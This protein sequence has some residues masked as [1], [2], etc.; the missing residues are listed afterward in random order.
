[1]LIK[2]REEE[3]RQSFG[4]FFDKDP[5]SP[6]ITAQIRQVEAIIEFE[7][8]TAATVS[9]T[10]IF[11]RRYIRRTAV[12]TLMIVCTSLSGIWFVA[13]YA[14]IFL[15]GLG[16]HNPY[17]INVAFSCC[18]LAGSFLSP[19]MA[20]YV[21]RRRTIIV[22]FAVMASSMLIFSAVSTGLGASSN[23]AR[24]VLVA[25]LCIWFF[26]FG[27]G[28]GSVVW[29]ASAEQHSVQYR[30]YSQAFALWVAF[31]FSFGGNFW[32]PYMLNKD[33]GNMGTNVGYF[34]FGLN[35]AAAIFS[36]FAVPET[37]R[38]TL[39]QI[40][41]F[42]ETGGK[43]WKTSLSQNKKVEMSNNQQALGPQK[44]ERLE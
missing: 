40:D 6:E 30:T 16:F 44:E 31:L 5:H 24:S 8:N 33:Y 41:E 3:A 27:S 11:K 28:P 26:T 9:W 15:A 2:A 17:V 38:L 25:F 20:E 14:T 7:R 22:G 19:F 37:A 21:G 36:F 13:P 39:E 34:Y 43:A 12:A 32:T 18:N 29:V 1:L 10:E 35:A 4:R 23:E 42:Y